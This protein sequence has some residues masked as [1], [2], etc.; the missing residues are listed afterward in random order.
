MAFSAEYGIH[1]GQT[2]GEF[3]REYA[4]VIQIPLPE[5]DAIAAAHAATVQGF[6]QQLNTP[7]TARRV[8]RNVCLP[9]DG[10]R[11]FGV[12]LDLHLL[13]RAQHGG[14]LN[15]RAG[16]SHF[17]ERLEMRLGDALGIVDVA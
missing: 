17:V 5:F 7:D 15:E 6:C 9:P 13:P 12:G 1:A 14:H 11:K 3:L 4:A 16:G 8:Q 2:I 10:S